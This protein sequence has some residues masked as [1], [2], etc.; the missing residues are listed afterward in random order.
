L[1]YKSKTKMEFLYTLFIVLAFIGIAFFL[2]NLRQIFTGKEFRGTCGSN[3]PFLK[4]KLGAC[5]VC[6]KKPEEE[7]KGDTEQRAA[8]G[9]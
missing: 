3:S 4:E 1:R 7:C 5:S 2:I 9:A 8:A 6:G